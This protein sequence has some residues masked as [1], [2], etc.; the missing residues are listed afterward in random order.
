MAN[1][2]YAAGSRFIA[3]AYRD[4]GIELKPDEHPAKVYTSML[5]KS[6]TLRRDLTKGP[7]AFRSA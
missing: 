4:Y 2:R 6:R 7:A 1:R 3:E 5:L